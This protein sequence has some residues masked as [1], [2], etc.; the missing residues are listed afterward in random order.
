M[1]RKLAFSLVGIALTVVILLLSPLAG[2]SAPSYPLP[3]FDEVITD[4]LNY[5]RDAQDN[6]GSIGGFATSAW[7]TMAI[8]AAG[9]DPH[10]WRKTGGN[11]SIVDYLRNNS[12]QVEWDKATDI[13]RSILAIVATCEDPAD[14]GGEDY[15]GALKALYDGNQI[16]YPDTVNDD[17]WG[18]LALRAAG[19]PLNSP[20]IVNVSAF[21]IANQHTDGGWSLSTSPLMT[22]DVDNTAAA[23]MALIAAGLPPGNESIEAGLDYIA[24]NQ[25]ESGG[26]S[27]GWDPANRDSTAWAI[28]AIKAAGQDP[29]GNDWDTSSGNTSVDFLLSLRAIDGS[30]KYSVGDAKNPEW[31]TA[32]AIPALLGIPYPILPTCPTPTPTPTASATIPP[33]P[34]P[35]PTSTPSPTGEPTPT[36]TGINHPTPTPTPTATVE[37]TYTPTAT[38]KSEPSP[39]PTPPPALTGGGQI[40]P[41]GGVLATGDGRLSLSFPEGAVGGNTTVTIQPSSCPNLPG[42]FRLGDTCF[43]ITA[44]ADG[45]VINEFKQHVR[46]CIEYT[47]EDVAAAGGDPQQLRLAYYDE[48]AGEWVALATVLDAESGMV[49]AEVDH[50]SEWAVIGVQPSSMPPWWALLAA[51]TLLIGSVLV[52]LLVIQH[53]RVRRAKSPIEGSSNENIDREEI[54]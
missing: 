37:P 43:S 50:L 49:C 24:A 28:G 36:P 1:H 21:I 16:G 40:T 52:F 38:P 26:F 25:E 46:I 30:F 6:D 47:E 35:T 31:G 4:A 32:Y 45:N 2:A 12:N 18:I 9:E 3:P 19:E 53:N 20:I 17:F 33:T 51:S 22:S 5:L 48:S 29:V 11:S 42:G 8:V 54:E 14:F 15:I 34:S 27:S 23:I 44:E 39:T 41:S 7:V 10:D 13:E